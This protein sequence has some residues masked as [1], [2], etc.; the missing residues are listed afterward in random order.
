MERESRIERLF[1]LGQ[2]KNIKFDDAFLGIPESLAADPDFMSKLQL[3]QM[4]QIDIAYREYVGLQKNIANLSLED[5]M[6]FLEETRGSIYDAIRQQ[7]KNGNSS[8]KEEK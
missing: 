8:P 6:A 3:L 4:I 5:S 7:I 2:Y 1:T